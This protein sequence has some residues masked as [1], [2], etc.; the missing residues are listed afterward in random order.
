LKKPSKTRAK[1]KARARR[2]QTRRPGEPGIRSATRAYEA[3]LRGQTALNER[4]LRHKH[5]A[6][7]ASPFA[8]LR[9]TY[10]RWAQ[11]WPG[12][13]PDLAGAPVVT[14]VGD[15]HIENFG[16]WR[17][18]EG[19]LAWGVNDFDEAAP[20]AYTNDLVRLA[21]SAFLAIRGKRLGLL[22]KAVCA[23]L[24]KGYE[25]GLRSG[26]SPVVLAERNRKLG[27]RVLAYL[28]QPRRFWVGRMGQSLRL[29]PGPSPAAR[30]VLQRALPPGAHAGFIRSRV[31]GLGSL[32]RPRFVAIAEWQGGLVAR[33]AKAFAPSAVV[34]ATGAALPDP[35]D[36]YSRQLLEGAIRSKDP[37]LAVSP[38]WIV[39]RLSPDSGKVRLAN[40]GSV[41]LEA[42]IMTLMG[43]ELAN[44]HLATPG[45]AKPILRHLRGQGPRWLRRAAAAMARRVEEDHQAWLPPS[46]RSRTVV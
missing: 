10:Y 9:A 28:I 2:A 17:D 39:R 21:T 14:C 44:V 4:D 6:M 7:G 38:D 13:C 34:W 33:E 8:F 23:L 46:G 43:K 11:V 27:E 3:W 32:G 37:F 30:A 22:E 35:P 12:E 5:K 29:Q 45:A 36:A 16:T 31:A 26:G 18:A 24:L 41:E 15:L 19:R 1:H 20:L 42:Q 25:A 40:L